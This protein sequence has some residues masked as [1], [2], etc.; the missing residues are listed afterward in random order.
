[1]E[2]AFQRLVSRVRPMGNVTRKYLRAVERYGPLLLARLEAA[3]TLSNIHLD[4]TAPAPTEDFERVA[5][6]GR[7]PDEKLVLLGTYY[8]VQ[9]LHQNARA[10]EQLAID[11]AED[12]DRLRSYDAF[13]NRAEEQ[14]SLLVTTYVRHVLRAVMRPGAGRFALLSVGTRGHQDDIDVAVIDVGGDDRVELER[15]MGRLASQCLRFAS[16]IDN[17]LAGEVGSDGYCV[18]IGELR[19]AL[20]SGKLGC[21]VVTELLRAELLAGDPDLLRQLQEEVTAEYFFEPRGDN[22]RHELYLRGLLGETRSLLLRP[23]PRDRVNP[24]DDGLRMI[25]G[26]V[27][28]LSTIEGIGASRQGNLFDE[29]ISWRPHLVRPLSRLRKA[30]IFLETFR[31]A[32]QLLVAQEDDLAVEGDAAVENLAAVAAALG[33]RDWG[34]VHAVSHLLVHYHEAVEASRSVATVLM[35]EVAH[36]LTEHG[37]FSRWAA[38]APR[39][40]FAA[41]LAE[42]LVDAARGFWGVRFYD[43]LLEAF[44][45]PNGAMLDAFVRSFARRS[46]HERRDLALL[47]ADWGCD[48]PYAFLRILTLAATR[49]GVG[50]PADPAGEIS[51]AFLTRLS[52]LPETVRALSR[53]FRS[54]PALANRFLFTLGPERLDRLGSACDVPIG[55]SEVAAARDSFQALIRVH[56]QS[57][58]YI[59]RVLARVT[60]RHP[61]TVD[62]LSD[63]ATLRTLALGRLAA[64]ERHPNAEE[65][66]GLLGDF[67]DIEFLRIAMGTLRGEPDAKA[68]AGFSELTATYLDRLFDFCFRQAA[69]E[70]GGW[71]PLRERLGILLAGGNARRRPY[72]E[73]YDLLALID[74]SDPGDQQFAERVVVLMNRQIARRGVVAQY[75]LAEH[76]RRFVTTFDELVALLSKDDDEVFVDRCQVLGSRIVVGGRRIEEQLEARALRPL[77]FARSDRFVARVAR[78]IDERRR[79]FHPLPKGMLHLKET[80]GGLREIDLSLAIAKARHC[81]WDSSQA[82]VFPEL[83]RRDPSRASL[84]ESLG[85][86]SDFLVSVRSAYRVAV[87]ATDEIERSRL[88]GPARTLGYTPDGIDAA[89]QLF[90]DIEARMAESAA[91]V[92]ELVAL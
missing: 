44:S 41:E 51:D 21:V 11:L 30:R 3:G 80:P 72:D 82:K 46:E 84:Y 57:S 58:H 19:G 18:G 92:N 16:P 52:Q 69:R 91:L 88:D 26:L 45:A 50:R 31:L 83:S 10:L 7:D 62:A 49:S 27:T 42:K 35:E 70:A 63:D 53:V 75:R 77:V 20:R 40:E 38:S 61:A 56:R 33:Y 78:E 13:V 71:V 47:Y 64:S 48:A 54:Y 81:V 14:F 29:L 79:A 5:A 74:S 2:P 55:D 32:V 15:A 6:A 37:P 65:Q 85:A 12:P 36:H 73:D 60:E 4:R 90:A 17:Y 39:E 68:R 87:A 24:K 25:L 76:F 28:A 67:Y 66:K 34:P 89:H 59:L 43:D 1:M 9:Y 86:I 22:S 8:C 23:L